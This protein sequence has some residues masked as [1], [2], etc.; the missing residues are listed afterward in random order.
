MRD[1]LLSRIARQF[2]NPR[3]PFRTSRGHRPEFPTIPSNSASQHRTAEGQRRKLPL[4]TPDPK[5]PASC[6]VPTCRNP[7]KRNGNEAGHGRTFLPKSPSKYSPFART[8]VEK[9][10]RACPELCYLPC[11]RYECSAAPPAATN[12]LLLF[13]LLLLLAAVKGRRRP[14]PRCR[15]A[16][17]NHPPARQ[18]AAGDAPRATGS[19]RARTAIAPPA[20]SQAGGSRYLWCFLVRVQFASGRDLGCPEACF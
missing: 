7:E 14:L 12:I 3:F 9:P 20:T 13:P 17:P 15:P 19:R 6:Y 8:A 2:R 4:P 10:L 16:T 1:L 5:R 18:A 11:R